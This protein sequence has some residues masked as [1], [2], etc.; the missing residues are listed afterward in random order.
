MIADTSCQLVISNLGGQCA[1]REQS[2]DISQKITEIHRLLDYL[3]LTGVAAMM[4]RRIKTSLFAIMSDHGRQ[5]NLL[6]CYFR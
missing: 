4:S 1:K 3:T 5:N 6:C 2:T